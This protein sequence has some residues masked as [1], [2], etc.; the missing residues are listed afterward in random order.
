MRAHTPR[1]VLAIA[2][3]LSPEQAQNLAAS[4]LHHATSGWRTASTLCDEEA[5][6]AHTALRHDDPARDRAA[7]DDEAAARTAT[8]DHGRYAAIIAVQRTVLALHAR[9][10][11]DP[12]RGRRGWTPD[13][14]QRM[15]AAWRRA[16]GPLPEPPAQGQASLDLLGAGMGWLVRDRDGRDL[17]RYDV[18]AAAVQD[19]DSIGGHVHAWSAHGWQPLWADAT[20]AFADP[21]A[22]DAAHTAPTT[23]SRRR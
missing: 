17:A 19:A 8:C 7:C 23:E 14:Y 4:L 18:L 13:A 6:A 11:V 2:A 1:D 5:I 16:I 20:A 12:T 10:L 22:A 9:D 21:L 3:T 15:T